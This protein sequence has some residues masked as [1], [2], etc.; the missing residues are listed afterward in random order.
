MSVFIIGRILLSCCVFFGKMIIHYVGYE[1]KRLSKWSLQI[2]FRTLIYIVSFV[3]ENVV[4]KLC[5]SGSI[6]K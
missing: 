1:S 3:M 5:G 6:N 4:D 2:L